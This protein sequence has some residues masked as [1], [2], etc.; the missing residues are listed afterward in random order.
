MVAG[1]C[2][3]VSVY[4]SLSVY[5]SSVVSSLVSM[6]VLDSISVPDSVSASFPDSMPGSVSVSFPGSVPGSVFGSSSRTPCCVRL[7]LRLWHKA[8]HGAPLRAR[9]CARLRLLPLVK[10]LVAGVC[11]GRLQKLR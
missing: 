6:S 5:R 10:L 1:V 3:G 2:A 4:R 8:E 9:L 11:A 7:Q